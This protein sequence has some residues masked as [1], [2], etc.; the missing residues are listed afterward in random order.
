LSARAATLDSLVAAVTQK[1]LQSMDAL[2]IGEACEE[3][4]FMIGAVQD[5]VMRS[6][7]AVLAYR[8]FRDSHV[9]GSEN[10]A[11]HVYDRWFATFKAVFE[12]IEDL[13]EAEMYAWVNRRSLI[14]A[15]APQIKL[16]NVQGDTLIV[17][18]CKPNPEKKCAVPGCKSPKKCRCKSQKRFTVL[19]F[20]STSCPKCLYTS[21]KLKEL[22][23]PKNF[24]AD[25]VTVYTGNDREAWQSYI[26]RELAL[27]PKTSNAS[28]GTQNLKPAKQIKVCH[29]QGTEDGDY[30][31]QYG[32]VQTPRLFL[33]DSEG[34]IIGRG[35]DA[36]ALNTL[37]ER[38]ICS[39]SSSK[40]LR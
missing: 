4:D 37:L 29:L 39:A 25:I 19:Y 28:T 20:Y 30:T 11:V 9:M 38:L 24:R 23:F 17:P 14:G 13:D 40:M 2:S 18:G 31:L 33:I 36:E 21:L 12:N 3:V 10:V 16:I 8:H 15:K 35:L 1:Y 34:I 32:V 26:A 22:T 5:S 27:E 6:E 7:V